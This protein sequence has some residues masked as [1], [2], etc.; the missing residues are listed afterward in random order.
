MGRPSRKNKTSVGDRRTVFTEC[1]LGV[2]APT[3]AVGE[4]HYFAEADDAAK[5]GVAVVAG[6]GIEVFLQGTVEF[7]LDLAL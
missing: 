4:G 2:G 1:R 5:R 7:I 3:G 6:D